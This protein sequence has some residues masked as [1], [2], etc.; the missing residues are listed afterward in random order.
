MI[1]FD[2][3][4]IEVTSNH[5]VT[6]SCDTWVVFEHD[7]SETVAFGTPEYWDEAVQTVFGSGYTV[8]EIVE[9]ALPRSACNRITDHK[10]VWGL[11]GLPE[12]RAN[13]PRAWIVKKKAFILVPHT[14]SKR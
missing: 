11:L 2:K 3:T 13:S 7:D 14:A 6:L 4:N 9:K 10:K 5:T 12:G 1:H 8:W